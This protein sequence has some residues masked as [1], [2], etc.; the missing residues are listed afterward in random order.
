MRSSFRSRSIAFLRRQELAL[1]EAPPRGSEGDMA[2]GSRGR[3]PI[4]RASKIGHR[5]IINDPS[6]TA[7]LAKCHLPKAAPGEVVS[8]LVVPIPKPPSDP[9]TAV[10]AVDGSFREASIQQDYPFSSI[11]FFTLGPL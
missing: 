7:L 3:R 5:E 4:E 10:I 6:V 1:P 8:N 11:T 9:I 2:Y